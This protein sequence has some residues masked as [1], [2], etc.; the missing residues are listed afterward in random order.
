ML[1]QSR[2]SATNT[3]ET[4]T[5]P[6]LS[7]LTFVFVVP[8]HRRHSAR[9]TEG[10][11]SSRKREGDFIWC[12]H[13]CE[14]QPNKIMLP[15]SFIRSYMVCSFKYVDINQ[16]LCVPASS[17]MKSEGQASWRVLRRT[18]TI[19]WY[20]P[21]DYYCFWNAKPKLQNKTSGW[22]SCHVLHVTQT[23]CEQLE[24]PEIP[25][26]G[27]QTA[28][29]SDFSL[30]PFNLFLHYLCLSSHFNLVPLHWCTSCIICVLQKLVLFFPL[31]PRNRI[32]I[33]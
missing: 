2:T 28:D 13:T 4:V 33:K 18:N 3:M 5:P 22:Q 12:P 27:G 16:H 31:N 29:L 25:A 15:Q 30:S 11:I 1:H 8:G 24:K 21:N 23:K 26:D 9:P 10:G 20:A 7:L 19:S 32:K 17:C 6:K 14:V